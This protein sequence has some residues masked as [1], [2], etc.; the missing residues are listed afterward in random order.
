MA[1]MDPELSNSDGGNGYETTGGQLMARET[2]LRNA[3]LER[4]PSQK[5][6]EKG[7]AARGSGMEYKC[8]EGGEIFDI[9]NL[10][11]GSKGGTEV[12][13]IN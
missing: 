1:K 11:E 9:A 2:K 10:P 3:V 13:G 12:R 4:L 8:S 5:W 6:R 7:F